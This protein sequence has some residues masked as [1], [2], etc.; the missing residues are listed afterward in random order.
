MKI[1]NMCTGVILLMLSVCTCFATM[2]GN[3]TSAYMEPFHVENGYYK[4]TTFKIV[5]IAEAKHGGVSEEDDYLFDQEVG[6][7]LK[8]TVDD[9]KQKGNPGCETFKESYFLKTREDI[10]S[11]LKKTTTLATENLKMSLSIKCVMVK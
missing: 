3:R 10:V 5:V 8:S 9:M 6:V 1:K 7:I 2:Q 11:V 4:G